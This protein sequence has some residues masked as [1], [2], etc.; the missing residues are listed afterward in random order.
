VLRQL[1][2]TLGDRDTALQKHG[3]QLVDQ[4]RPLPN[5]PIAHAMQRLYVELCLIL[6]LDEPHGR[7]CRRLG[8][9]SASRSSFFCAFT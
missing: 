7:S 8:I 1:P 9:A 2:T 5:K 6:Q 4:R 3:T